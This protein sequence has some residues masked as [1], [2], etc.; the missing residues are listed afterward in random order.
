[1]ASDRKRETSEYDEGPD[2]ARRFERVLGRVLTVSKA[3][4]AKR[5][6]EQKTRSA[7]PSRRK[8]K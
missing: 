7:K 3:E 8:P 2:A 5:E 4:L 1:M 6:S